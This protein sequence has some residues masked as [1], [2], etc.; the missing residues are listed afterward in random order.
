MRAAFFTNVILIKAV[1]VALI[2]TTLV[3][4]SMESIE[5]SSWLSNKQSA[6][7][8]SWMNGRQR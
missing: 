5:K 4:V 8:S 1:I 3:S 6:L 2:L 7:Q